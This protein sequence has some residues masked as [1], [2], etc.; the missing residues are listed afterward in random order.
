MFDLHRLLSP[1]SYDWYR[2]GLALYV[3]DGVLMSL[4]QS[5]FSNS[6]RL[7]RVIQSWIDTQST[8]VTWETVIL[9]VE[10]PI[11]DN[12]KVA[13]K[14]REYVTHLNPSDN[15]TDVV[16]PGKGINYMYVCSLYC[17]ALPVLLKSC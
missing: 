1:I 3:R 6:M 17:L 2:V 10:S 8:P 12:M 11:V 16:K 13:A 14:L 9:A 15:V 7:S 4:D 5:N